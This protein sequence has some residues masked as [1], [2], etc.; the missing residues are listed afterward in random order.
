MFKEQQHT[1]VLVSRE[2]ASWTGFLDVVSFVTAVWPL[3]VLT[4]KSI[5]IFI[6]LFMP[7][8]TVV[9]PV[10]GLEKPIFFKDNR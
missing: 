9:S 6:L 10:S 3:L 8:E 4:G 5:K 2:V 1:L 7:K